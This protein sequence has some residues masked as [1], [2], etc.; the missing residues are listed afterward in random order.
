[1]KAMHVPGQT[2]LFDRNRLRLTGFLHAEM[3]LGIAC[4]VANTLRIESKHKLRKFAVAR[5]VLHVWY[6]RNCGASCDPACGRE[7]VYSVDIFC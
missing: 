1:M 6:R 2:W 7:A 4:A 3:S 5:L